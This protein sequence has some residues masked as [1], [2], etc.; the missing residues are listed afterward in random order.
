MTGII[1]D[2][3]PRERTGELLCILAA[4][5][6]DFRREFRERRDLSNIVRPTRSNSICD[7]DCCKYKTARRVP[8]TTNNCDCSPRRWSQGFPR[9]FFFSYRVLNGLRVHLTQISCPLLSQTYSRIRDPRTNVSNV[10]ILYLEARSLDR[11][12]SYSLTI[13]FERSRSL[14]DKCL[15]FLRY[16]CSDDLNIFRRL[17]RIITVSILEII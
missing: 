17:F 10:Q 7:R 14:D 8:E 6:L 3:L 11:S 4:V 2:Y 16:R 12:S 13:I 15:E 5:A 1:E 9:K